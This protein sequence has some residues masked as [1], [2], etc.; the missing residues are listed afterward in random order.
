LL[1]V[2]G[3]PQ[4]IYQLKQAWPSAVGALDLAQDSKEVSQFSVTFTYNWF[5]TS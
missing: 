1:D 5:T 2:K 3:D 4:M